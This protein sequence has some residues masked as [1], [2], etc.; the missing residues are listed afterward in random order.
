[1]NRRKMLGML[2]AAVVVAAPAHAQASFQFSTGNVDGRMAMAS[3]LARTGALENEAADDFVLTNHTR[4]TSASFIGLVP[5]G[6]LPD[7]SILNVE[8]YRV[9]PFDSKDPPSGKVPTRVKSPSDDA[10]ATRESGSNLTYTTSVISREFRAQNSVLNGITVNGGG[11]GAVAGQ[12]VLFTVN[13]SDAFDLDAG[14]YFFVPQVQ[15]G[16]GEFYWL[17]SVR[18][19][20]APGSVFSPDLQ[21]WIRNSALDPDW[22]RVGTD[23]VGG[24]PAPTFNGAFTLQGEVVPEP[25]TY[26]LVATG[27]ALLGGFVRRRRTAMH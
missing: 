24:T 21:A 17:S 18:P 1:M 16:S 6:G 13:F 26:L 9:F 15:L 25:S 12:E 27:L 19:I 2:V 23:I 10:F 22:L 3:R 8:I 20:V 14:H 7:V 4:I 11:D 5:A